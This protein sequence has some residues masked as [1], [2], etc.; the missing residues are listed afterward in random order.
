MP[1][2]K[3]TRVAPWDTRCPGYIFNIGKFSPTLLQTPT[4]LSPCLLPHKEDTIKQLKEICKDMTKNAL[5]VDELRYAKRFEYMIDHI[6][7]HLIKE[8]ADTLQTFVSYSADVDKLR[9]QSLQEALP[10]LWEQIKDQ[11]EY[12][13][14]L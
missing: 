1:T 7:T 10:E 8:P 5:S 3:A 12:K 9:E 2:T 6:I 14:K 4:Y 11:V 13:G